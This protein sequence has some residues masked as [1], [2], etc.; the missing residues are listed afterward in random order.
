[1]SSQA[2]SR[3]GYAA[4]LVQGVVLVTFPAAGTIFTEPSQYGL[5]NTQ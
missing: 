3:T 2:E 1:M 4:G 5:S